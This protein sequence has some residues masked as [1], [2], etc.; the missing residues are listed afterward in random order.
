MGKSKEDI[1]KEITAHLAARG[2]RNWDEV[3]VGIAD[4]VEKRLFTDHRVE[5]DG[6]IWI[7]VRRIHLTAQEKLKNI[8]W[9]KAQKAVLVEAVTKRIMSMHTKSSL[10]RKSESGMAG[11]LGKFRLDFPHAP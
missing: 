7:Y 3:Y 11:A 5:K 6:G 2:I 4:D 9:N 8:F 1:I 10:I